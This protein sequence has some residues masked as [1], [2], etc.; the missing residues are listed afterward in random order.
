[1]SKKWPGGII[2]PTPAT[3]TGPYQTGTAPGIW[4]LSQQAFWQKQGLWPTAGSVPPVYALF[5]GG[6]TNGGGTSGLAIAAADLN[7]L[8]NFTYWGNLATAQTYGGVGLAS[9]TRGVFAGGNGGGTFTKTA[10]YVTFGTSGNATFF[11]NLTNTTGVLNGVAGVSSPTRGVIMGGAAEVSGSRTSYMGYITIAT[12]GNSTFFGNLSQNLDNLNQG[13][14]NGTRGVIAG[15]YGDSTGTSANIE[16]ITIASTGNATNFGSL[17]TGRFI[18][19][20]MSSSTRAVWAGGSSTNIIDYVTIAST[21]NATSFGS[22]L[23]T[24]GDAA[25]VNNST[26]GC[27]A[28]SGSV[29]TNYITIATTGNAVFF[30]NL[31]MTAGNAQMGGCCPA[32]GGL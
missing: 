7:T 2:T 27:V 20:G 24:A 18:A 9:T 3:P 22:L 19:A 6:F 29:G 11:G 23:F 32:Q 17:T 31:T 1:M 8:G 25:G 30:G 16:Y 10:Q 12:T 5:F 4:T 21:G 14:S 13:G 15:G 28:R 26:R